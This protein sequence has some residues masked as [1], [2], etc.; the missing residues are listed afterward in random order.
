MLKELT[1][2][3]EKQQKGRENSPAWM[4]GEQLKE[5]AAREPG[6]VDILLS[7][8]KVSSMSLVEAEK[9]IKE[10]SDKHRKGARSFCVSPQVAEGILREFYG[11]PKRTTKKAEEIEPADDQYFDLDSF[12]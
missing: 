5:I 4:V 1:K 2:I 7:D 11:L 10:Y 6:T 3:I 12:L 8:L 9:K